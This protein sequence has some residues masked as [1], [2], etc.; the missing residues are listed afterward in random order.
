MPASKEFVEQLLDLVEEYI[1]DPLKQE[2][3]VREL[4]KI[5]TENK[6]VATTQV[7]ILAASRERW[8][9]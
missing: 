2:A 5:P 8:K 1:P 6:S 9:A 7:R 4:Y 3:F